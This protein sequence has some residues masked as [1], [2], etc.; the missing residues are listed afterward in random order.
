MVRLSLSKLSRRHKSYVIFF[1]FKKYSG[2]NNLIGIS[3]RLFS[4]C[5]PGSI[6]EVLSVTAIAASASVKSET[7]IVLLI[8]LFYLHSDDVDDSIHCFKSL[9]Q[10]SGPFGA[11]NLSIELEYKIICK[12]FE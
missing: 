4:I 12:F 10:R 6:F 7:S 9:L 5:L 3:Q 8:S 11:G 1:S 2:R